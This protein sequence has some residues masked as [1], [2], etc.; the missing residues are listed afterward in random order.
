MKEMPE[1]WGDGRPPLFPSGQTLRNLLLWPEGLWVLK[2][3]PASGTKEENDADEEDD[4]EEGDEEE[5][6][7]GSKKGQNRRRLRAGREWF[8][9]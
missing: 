1:I 4:E 7:W 2:H 9:G 5:I 6:W 3:G 8:F